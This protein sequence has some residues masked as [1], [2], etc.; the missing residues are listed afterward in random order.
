ML[1]IKN[2]TFFPDAVI[3]DWEYRPINDKEILYKKYK[4]LDKVS[5]GGIEDE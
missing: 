4:S 3:D 1:V 2:G 5:R